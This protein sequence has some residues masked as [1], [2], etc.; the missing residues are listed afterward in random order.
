MQKRLI[1]LIIFLFFIA[2]FTK[3][4]NLL[5]LLPLKDVRK[6]LRM[7]SRNAYLEIDEFDKAANI[8]N[9]GNGKQVWSIRKAVSE[10]LIAPPVIQ[11]I[12]FLA[13]SGNFTESNKDSQPPL[14]ISPLL[15]ANQISQPELFVS[16]PDSQT[17]AL[18]I[19]GKPLR[20]YFPK[21]LLLGY[22]VP[23]TYPVFLPPE[24]PSP[25]L[26]PKSVRARQ[27]KELAKNFADKY[28]INIALVMA[29]MHSES[30]FSPMTVSSK[31]AMGLMQL[32][33]S[34]ASDEVHRF[35]YGRRGNIG[36][37]ELKIPE[38][39]IRYGIAYLH[40]LLTRYFQNVA[41]KDI[42]ELCVIASYNLG[43]NRFLKLYGSTQEI[44]VQNINAMSYA[45]F[46]KD[47]PERLPTRETRHYVE[48][49]KNMKSIYAAEAS[50][51]N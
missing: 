1:F 24:K 31:S 5:S 9:K 36:F 8:Q 27:Y 23:Q 26:L 3:D 42:K 16:L 11:A 46:L 22:S 40:I 45:D 19:S 48:K 15:S 41:N 10:N 34:T 2:I 21:N 13:E 25:P 51:T 30:N 47:L 50:Q 49:V 43:P 32:L 28:N 29:I 17:D 20:W 38:T 39:N 37:E 44:A 7:L 12:T 14:S 6:E 4:T 18:D 35:L 33:P